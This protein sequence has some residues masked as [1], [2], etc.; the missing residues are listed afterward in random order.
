MLLELANVNINGIVWSDRTFIEEGILHINK[1][2]I[3]NLLLRDNRLSDVKIELSSPGEDCVITNVIDVIE[4]RSKASEKGPEFLGA[5]DPYGVIGKGKTWVLKGVAVIVSEGLTFNNSASQEIGAII[6]MKESTSFLT[7]YSKLHNI[8]VLG[9]PANGITSKEYKIALK[10]AGLRLAKYLGE[11]AIGLK[12]NSIR[13]YNLDNP[14]EE[15]LSNLPRVAYIFQLLSTQYEPIEGDPV[16]YG[17][18]IEKIVPTIVIPTEIMD[19]AI[20]APYDSRYMETY[21]IQNHPILEELFLRHRKDFIFCGVIIMTAPNNAEEVER[22]TTIAANL[23]E[24]TLRAECAILTKA[25]GGAPEWV[26]MRVAQKCEQRGIKTALAFLHMGIDMTQPNTKPTTIFYAEEVDAMVSMGAP[27][28]T[29]RLS[30]TERVIGKKEVFEKFIYKQEFPLRY[31]RG[32]FS[33]L[34]NSKLK[35]IRY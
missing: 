6:P 17:G 1:K 35:A 8:I 27:L 19:G 22:V 31:I 29:I 16:F 9:A 25:G 5:V 21:F 11:V 24:Y 2:E 32:A 33:Q 7:P 15:N 10:T 23:V 13:I 34:G 20:T 18:N 14:K 26:M 28:G 4:P 3:Q 30:K 12:A